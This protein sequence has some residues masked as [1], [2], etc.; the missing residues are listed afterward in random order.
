MK[1]LVLGGSG[2]IG[3]RLLAHMAVTPGLVTVSAS[4]GRKPATAG[5]AAIR[6]DIRNEVALAVALADVDCVVNCVAG[7]AASIADGATTLVNAARTAGHPGIIHLST[8][9]VYGRQEGTLDE[10][11]RL[12]PELGWYAQAKCLAE[13]EIERY[14][15]LGGYAVILRPGCVYGP[16]S[17]LWV[18]RI[19]RLLHAGRLGDLGTQ[20]DGWSNLVHVD[21]VCHAV[22]AAI[23][24]MPNI[25]DHRETGKPAVFNLAA[26]DSP[27]WNEYF[28]DLA[29]AIGAVPLRRIGIGRV[30]ADAYIASPAVKIAEKI[31]YHIGLDRS[32][33][34]DPLPPGLL[35]LFGQQIRLDS[36]RAEAQLDMAWTPYATGLNDSV[37]SIHAAS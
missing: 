12:D 24:L 35:H 30:K 6:L 18:G 26:P 36:H 17:Q 11:A 29:L 37:Q 33:F 31:A 32:R 22:L 9:S 10:D 4:R 25:H 34:P 1:I 13:Q 3:R 20:G 2:H 7:D 5:V 23:H 28:R 14:V 27:R 15:D 8:M 19:A 21:D 16:D